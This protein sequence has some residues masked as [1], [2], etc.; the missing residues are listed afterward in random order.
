MYLQ[1]R[2]RLCILHKYAKCE[3]NAQSWQIFRITVYFIST[4]T[5][6]YG[7]RLSIKINTNSQIEGEE[8]EVMCKAEVSGTSERIIRSINSPL[9][10]QSRAREKIEVY[11]NRVRVYET[12][13]TRTVAVLRLARTFEFRREWRA[14]CRR[15]KSP[16]AGST[17]RTPRSV[18]LRAPHRTC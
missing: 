13:S 1:Q 18:C 11:S 15:P 9:N 3:V 2:S 16:F 6:K 14:R 12:A 17:P 4:T 8:E 10:E 5:R 7:Q